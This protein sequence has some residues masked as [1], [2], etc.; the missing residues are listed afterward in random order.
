MPPRR[1]LAAVPEKPAPSPDLRV[2]VRVS[3]GAMGWLTDTDRALAD[4]AVK[5]AEQIELAQQRAD[6]LESLW[7]EVRG[8]KSLAVKLAKLEAM[9]DVTKTV[10][11]LGPQLQGV[12][13]DLGG[14]PASRRAMQPDK[15]I[16]GRL[17]A[18]RAST[19]GQRD[20]APVDEA[21]SPSDA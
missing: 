1:K 12:L 16:G 15:P 18:L 5:L 7:S 13:R 3:I 4:V 17:A 8:D 11:W 14:T 19:G 10:G 20:A 9:C 21:A 2:S 6:L